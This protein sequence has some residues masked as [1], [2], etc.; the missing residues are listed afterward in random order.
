MASREE[1][2]LLKDHMALVK[3]KMDEEC[4]ELIKDKDII[5]DKLEFI[6]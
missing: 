5:K 1:L 4:N 2:E 3:R 6:S